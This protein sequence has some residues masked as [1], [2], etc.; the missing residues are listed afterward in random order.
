MNKKTTIE[1]FYTLTCPNCKLTKQM[2][3]EVLP[4]FEDK[5]SLKTTLANSPSGMIRT[6][7]LGIHTV[8][9]LLIDN[10]VVFKSVPTKEELIEKL[11]NYQ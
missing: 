9:T 1:L 8:P 7:K 4:Q 2:L 11:K 6:M 3:K 10:K 5:F